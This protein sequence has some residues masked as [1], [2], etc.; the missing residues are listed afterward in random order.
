[1][2]KLKTS[3][4]QTTL[5]WEDIEANLANF[6]QKISSINEETDLILLPEMFSTGFS[7]HPENIAEKP[8]GPTLK[9]MQDQ[10]QKKN[11]AISGRW[12][13]QET[14][15]YYNSVYFVFTDG[16]YKPNDKRHLY[17]F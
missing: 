5:Q 15:N 13:I 3:I 9:W 7:M 14:G 16:E 2:E 17:L 10:D 8:E 11:A 6:S 4:I 1:M 12:T